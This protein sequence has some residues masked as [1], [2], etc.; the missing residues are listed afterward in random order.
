MVLQMETLRESLRVIDGRKNG[1]GV[2]DGFEPDRRRLCRRYQVLTTN[3]SAIFPKFESWTSE[4]KPTWQSRVSVPS[5]YTS[6]S[7]HD[8][9]KERSGGTYLTTSGSAR[10]VSLTRLRMI[11][12]V[13]NVNKN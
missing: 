3:T 6:G 10:N 1:S 5:T 7:V 2:V 4:G 13:S 12:F 8:R 9:D 11:G